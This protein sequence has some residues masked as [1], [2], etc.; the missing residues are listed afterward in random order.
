MILMLIEKCLD[1]YNKIIYAKPPVE[2]QPALYYKKVDSNK[3]LKRREEF[4]DNY[5]TIKCAQNSKYELTCNTCG[6]KII[7]EIDK[8]WGNSKSKSYL[9]ECWKEQKPYICFCD[10]CKPKNIDINCKNCKTK[11]F[12]LLYDESRESNHFNIGIGCMTIHN[13][14]QNSKKLCRNCVEKESCN[15][16]DFNREINYFFWELLFN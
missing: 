1:F 4:D 9:Y 12:C 16:C 7:I 11:D 13:A 14:K 10:E 8:N 5:R 3:I 2:I 6:K 15:F